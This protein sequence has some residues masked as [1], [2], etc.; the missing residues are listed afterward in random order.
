[1]LPCFYCHGHLCERND[2]SKRFCFYENVSI[3]ISA[4]SVLFL[5]NKP[6]SRK[7]TRMT[8]L[9]PSLQIDVVWNP[10]ITQ[11]IVLLWLKLKMRQDLSQQKIDWWIQK[12]MFRC[13]ATSTFAVRRPYTSVLSGTI[14]V[15][16]F[17]FTTEQT[18][19][20]KWLSIHDFVLITLG[21]FYLHGSVFQIEFD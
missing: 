21:Q 17:A 10:S 12:L 8:S 6:W 15:S 9:E 4:F 20:R 18:L 16:H 5:I 1:M 2:A 3:W 7:F 14:I 13:L 19:W 11:K